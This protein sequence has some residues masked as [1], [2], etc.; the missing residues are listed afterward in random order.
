MDR[1][2][3]P[4]RGKYVSCAGKHKGCIFCKASK[5]NTKDYVVF[6][7]KSSLCMLNIFPY[8]NGHLMVSPLRHTKDMASLTQKEILDLFSSLNK[9]KSLL[10]KILKPHGYNIGIN[11]SRV[12]GAGVVGHLHIHIV[13]RW[14][15]D[16]N[17]MPV[18]GQ[19]KVISQSLRELHRKLKH[20]YAKKI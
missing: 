8:N 10:D 3:A 6:K 4:W 14:P 16:T 9:A 20:A 2:W 12:A 17:F 11:I 13:P 7:T 15:G 1:L 5:R 18:T 19:T